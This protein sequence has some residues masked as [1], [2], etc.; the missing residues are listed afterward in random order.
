VFINGDWTYDKAIFRIKIDALASD[1][2]ELNALDLIVDVPDLGQKG[3]VVVDAG[4]AAAGLAVVFPQSFHV[5][6]NIQLTLKGGTTPGTPIYLSPT[7]NG[8]TLKILDSTNTGIA[9][10]VAWRADAY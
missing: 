8:F 1:R 5:V 9:G 2:V 4:H 6:P 7:V 10:T 3:E